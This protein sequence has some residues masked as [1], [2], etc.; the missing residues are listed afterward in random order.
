MATI[1]EVFDTAIQHHKAGLLDKAK[2]S[3]EQVLAAQPLHPEA[4]HLLGLIEHRLGKPDTAT[5]LIRKAI[6]INGAPRYYYGLGN[7]LSQ[8]GDYGGALACFRS[9][10]SLAPNFAR[11]HAALGDA[12]FQQGEIE[13]ACA[14]YR[15]ALALRPNMAS[16][17][18]NLGLASMDLGRLDT[19]VEHCRRAIALNPDLSDGH[20]NLGLALLLQGQF[21][22]GWVH[23]EWRWRVKDLRIGV[24]RFERQPWDGAPLNGAHI[25]L[26]AEQGVG[27]TVQFVRYVPLVVERG[28]R[29]LLEVQPELK[30]FIGSMSGV[31]QIISRGEPL[32]SFTAHCPFM[33]LPLAF[34]TEPATIPSQVPYLRPDAAQVEKWNAR[35][36]RLPGLRVGLVWG[37]RPEHR[38]D[39]ARSIPL[40]AFAPLFR[41]DKT[42]YF[43]LQ[44][45]SAAAQ[46]ATPPPG[47]P[48]HDVAPKLDDIAD[49]AA[50][51]AA[52]DLVISVDTSVAH[53][54]GAIGKP[55][56]ILLPHVPD[57][58]WLLGRED[59]PWYPSAR[60]FRQ[61]TLGAWA[62]VI[63]RMAAELSG[64]AA[65]IG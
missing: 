29:V 7:V 64:L 57:W 56:W 34:G 17:H 32:P 58:R 59:S 15:R 63:E 39:R 16:V 28:G 4:L 14:A 27:D 65:A 37:G 5:Q 25:L 10:V 1:A 60:L 53:V 35:F 11:A 48:L 44:K 47:L 62:P 23:H 54:A 41:V 46:I 12:L 49:T 43:S 3:Y 38:R 45:G 18:A 50:A 8:Q 26:H 13:A 55:V 21:A 51:I 9:A 52:L 33:S 2:A 31:E 40:A 20:N 42:V 24:R 36:K 61:P 22:E 6:T 19:A 30:R